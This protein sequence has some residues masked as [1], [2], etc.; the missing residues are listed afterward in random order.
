[1]ILNQS[2][3][4]PVSLFIERGRLY[5]TVGLFKK[6]GKDFNQ[7]YTLSKNTIVDA[8][9]ALLEL[10]NLAYLEGK[11]EK[12]LSFLNNVEP[13]VEKSRS[14]DLDFEFW[15]FKG[16]AFRIKGDYGAALSCY[17]KLYKQV[18]K[19]KEKR[20]KAV[21]LN[22]MGLAYRGAGKYCD[23]I[24]YIERAD[25]IFGSI[26]DIPAQ[27]TCLGNIGLVYAFWNRAEKAI[28]YFRKAIVI[29]ENTQSKGLMTSPL[30]NWGIALFKLGKYDKALEKWQ[31]ALAITSAQGDFAAIAM[32]NNNI[33]YLFIKKGQ[34]KKALENLNLALSMKKKLNLTGYLPSTY[35]GLAET[36]H[37]LF[38]KTNRKTFFKKA[39]ENV[40]KAYTIAKSFNNQHDIKVSKGIFKTLGISVG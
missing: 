28:P 22:L 34:Y 10:A 19:K 24:N 6:A 31:E 15:R 29:L 2:N 35:N 1:M 3:K 4:N 25:R 38:L 37:N 8:A 39:K 36:Y 20:K 5:S 21:I 26:G 7:A 27:G 30:L 40:K 11:I 9:K 18:M 23:A 12:S 17:K 13:Y 32:I 16:N 14:L 33:G